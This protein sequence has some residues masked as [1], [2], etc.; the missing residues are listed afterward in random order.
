MA[1]P[2]LEVQL[3]RQHIFPF[4]YVMYRLAVRLH[5]NSQGIAA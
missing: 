4:V 2:A 1:M 5:E 3:S